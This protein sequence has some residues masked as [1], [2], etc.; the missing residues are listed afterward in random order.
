MDYTSHRLEVISSVYSIRTVSFTLS[1]SYLLL[2]CSTATK[3]RAPTEWH[4]FRQSKR[5]HHS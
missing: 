4:V 3:A 1:H 2:F 5:T